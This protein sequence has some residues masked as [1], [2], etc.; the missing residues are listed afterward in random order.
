MFERQ[1]G[2]N[3]VLNLMEGEPEFSPRTRRLAG[4]E[5]F[6]QGGIPRPMRISFCVSRA[7]D[8][9]PCNQARELRSSRLYVVVFTTRHNPAVAEMLEWYRSR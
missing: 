8:N 5:E 2:L 1:I 9:F 7:I 3:G 6:R 4:P